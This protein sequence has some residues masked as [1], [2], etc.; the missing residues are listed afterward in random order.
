MAGPTPAVKPAAPQ[1][2]EI[3]RQLLEF[4]AYETSR[5]EDAELDEHGR[6]GYRYLDHYWTEKGRH[7]Y[8]I[9]VGL[10]IAGMALVREGPP[11][12]IAEFLIMP[13]HRR[14][15]VGTAAA[16]DVLLRYPGQWE[17]RQAPGNAAAVAFWRHAIPREFT[18]RRDEHGTT[19]TFTILSPHR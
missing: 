5:F 17:V 14:T 16:R 8:L 3:L 11:H 1:D 6:F 4:N 7:P 10:S 13:K 2:K 15:G 19:Q 12:S 9:L 18:E